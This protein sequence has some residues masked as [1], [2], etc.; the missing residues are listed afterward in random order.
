MNSQKEQKGH[1]RNPI[2]EDMPRLEEK[3]LWPEGYIGHEDEYVIVY[4]GKVQEFIVPAKVRYFVQPYRRP[5]VRR[6]DDQCRISC[7]LLAM[8]TYFGRVMR[9]LSY[10]RS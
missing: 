7:S 1:G 9:L 6:K 4:Q 2:P 5:V 3:V 10:W 8:R